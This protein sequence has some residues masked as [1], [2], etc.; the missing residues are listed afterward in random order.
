MEQNIQITYFKPEK[1]GVYPLN[2]GFLF[3]TEAES[4]ENCGLILY[5]KNGKACRI[6]FSKEGK[7]GTLYGVKVEGDE[8]PFTGYNYYNVDGEYTDPYAKSVS[9]LE[10]FGDFGEVKRKTRGVLTRGEF[11]W[12]E[13]VP[14]KTPYKDTIIYGLNVRSFTM[15]KSS[16]V[17]N[18]GT[19]EGILEKMD[20]LKEL[21][22]TAIELMP[23][24]EYDE[25]M[26]LSSGPV[27]SMEEAIR[28]C[29][30]REET[31]NRVNC[32]GYQKG[33]YF[34]PK[35]SYSAEKPDISFKKM[36]KTLHQNGIE[37]M[38]QFYFP[39]ELQ[40]SYIMDILKYWVIEYHID[41]VRLCGFQIPFAMIAQEPLL[42]ETKIRSDYFPTEEIYKDKPP[43]Y[44]NIAFNNGNFRN[45]MRRFLK[46]DEN[47]INQ[48]MFYHRNNPAN[49]AVVNFLA[50]YDGFSLF[51]SVAY[52]RK[53]NE[54]N[55]E[56]NR[57]G[58]DNN[59][60]WNC[61]AEGE[62]RKKA[63]LQLRMK[64]LK[65]ALSFLLLSQGVPYLFSG[66]EFA[67]TRFGNNNAYCQDNDI[68]NIKWK[69]G[70]FAEEI[71]S[72]TK[73]LIS[74]R[75]NH[76]V[77]HLAGEL[78]IMDS[79]GCGYPD[80]SY[81]GTE[82]WRPDTGYISRMVGIML[83]GKYVKDTEDDSLYIAYNMH[84]QPN[85][86]ALPNLPKGMK[87]EKILST[88]EGKEDTQL[89]DDNKIIA[90]ERSV[91]LYLAKKDTAYCEKNRKVKR[92]TI[93][94]N[95]SMETL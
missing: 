44:R 21:G 40:P 84:W 42:K 18:R 33:F 28:N 39:P 12:E 4:A 23:S 80:I 7:R 1:Q 90:E 64:Q 49:H 29:N 37:V 78:K 88:S 22:I 10:S 51:D 55:G 9:G 13:D 61:G 46:G 67:N 8:F 83:C 81:H 20:Y 72:F 66:D 35:A 70:K 59:F 30:S 11:D 38:M 17:K 85:R 79:L 54:K 71:L 82:A 6:P 91:A 27:T 24:Y 15:H 43:I 76:P 26:Y 36:V 3:A 53:H 2:N 48:V 74:L 62:S 25:C 73:E 57:D 94:K 87:W 93:K 5:E 77:L 41:G 58:T 31:V 75:K 56:D 47:L 95:E 69:T 52:E 34:A 50:D 14:L 45:D 32:W 16:G 92:K 65:N 19:F 68:W 86:L 60:S 89:P 63:I